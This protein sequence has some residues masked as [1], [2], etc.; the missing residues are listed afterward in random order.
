[1]D[2]T[3]QWFSNADLTKYENKYVSIVDRKVIFASDDPEIAYKKAKS[4]YPN[5][6]II[7]WKVLEGENYIF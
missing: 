4:K 5:K 6:E 2:K 7:L 1:M 3:S